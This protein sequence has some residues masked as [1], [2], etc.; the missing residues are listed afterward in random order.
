MFDTSQPVLVVDDYTSMTRIV[1]SLLNS[2]GFQNVDQAHD[3][4]SALA[5]LREKRYALVIT[6]LLMDGMSGLD[7]LRAMKADSALS[8]IPVI[9][10]SADR[11]SPNAATAL[12]AGA[13][14]YLAKPFGASTLRET[15]AAVLD[16]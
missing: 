16:R 3:G 2:C 13:S 10:M 8:A 15:I 7:L 12:A 9:V 1:T 5:A 14:A 11:P 4:E 6:D